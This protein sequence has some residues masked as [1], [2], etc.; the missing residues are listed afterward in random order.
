[1]DTYEAY[2][3]FLGELDNCIINGLLYSGY[4]KPHGRAW[5]K[6]REFFHN[7]QNELKHHIPTNEIENTM[8]VIKNFIL[9]LKYYV[10]KID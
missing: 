7:L 1:M 4:T 5:Y 6:N 10:K 8:T 9:V 3:Y 2:F